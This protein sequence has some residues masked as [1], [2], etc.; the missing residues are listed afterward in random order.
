MDHLLANSENPVP[1]ATAEGESSSTGAEDE[2]E[3]EALKM[4]IKKTGDSDEPLAN[5]SEI[6]SLGA[7]RPGELLC[8][9]ADPS[10]RSERVEAEPWNCPVEPHHCLTSSPSNAANAA[11]CSDLRLLQAFTLREAAISH[12]RSLPKRY[13]ATKF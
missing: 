8:H 9:P 1:E 6:S 7:Q 5:V 13:V 11:S 10:R 3:D 4:H 2:D 12:S